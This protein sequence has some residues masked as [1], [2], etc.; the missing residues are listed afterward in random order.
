[1]ELVDRYVH[2]VKRHLP[3]KQQDDI[4]NELTE[5]ILSQISDKTEELGRPL[6]EAEQEAVL[7]HYGH[8]YLL[9]MRY[10]PQQYL[11]GPSLFQFYMPALK[12]ALALAFAVQVIIA[13]SV[14]LSQHAPGQIIGW[15]TRFPGVA[16]QVVFWVTV[17]FAVADYWQAKLRLFDKWSPSTLPRVTKASQSARPVNLVIEVVANLI[18]I[19][20]WLAVPTYPFLMLGPAAAFLGLSPAWSQVYWAALAP[21]VVSTLLSLVNLFRPSWAWMPRV[22]SLATNVLSLFVVSVAI[23]AGPL[24]VPLKDSAD[25][26]RL[27]KGINDVT[28]AVLVI[29]SLITMAQILADVYRL[30]RSPSNQ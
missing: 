7:K 23:N 18:F 16:L 5:D 19:A 1:M 3:A 8:P 15:I 20:W 24:V 12:I 4:A 13:L 21:A 27:V 2:A 22:R 26:S 29:I 10:R 9:A 11:I 6:T 28:A 30:V 17:S 14:G 25:L